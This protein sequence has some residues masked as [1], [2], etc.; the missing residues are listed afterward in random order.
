MSILQVTFEDTSLN[1]HIINFFVDTDVSLQKRWI[2]LLKENQSDDSK[3]IHTYFSN[4]TIQDLP[5]LQDRINDILQFLAEGYKLPATV[6]NSPLTQ[7]ELND[8]HE[9]YEKYGGRVEELHNNFL[10]LNELI[11]TCESVLVTSNNKDM[12]LMH[13]TM[14]YYPQT[15]FS[16]LLEKDKL[17]LKTDFRWG[18]I[19]LGYNT[20][21][22]DWIS[23]CIDNDLKVIHRDMVKPQQR[24]SA[25]TW[26]H[27][28]AD[29][30]SNYTIRN[31]SKWWESLPSEA[32]EVIP[33]DN[34]NQLCLGRVLLGNV[35]ID[36]YF[37]AF[38]ANKDNWLITNS[39]TKKRWNVE[40]FSTFRKIIS[41]EI[42]E[43]A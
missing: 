11:H 38:D 14:D 2:D 3:N 43:N 17:F 16:P 8:L 37:L 31:F 9:Q 32:Q 13:C 35:I 41:V 24:F 28:G 19:Y 5:R 33:I 4:A 26:F 15:I 27:F 22:K 18:E 30:Y 42:F 12:P 1:K 20:L 21:G 7:I 39:D 23:V 25:E 6:G 29:D 10:E 40:V 36:D 34:L